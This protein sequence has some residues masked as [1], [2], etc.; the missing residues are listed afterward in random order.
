MTDALGTFVIK[1]ITEYP[2]IVWTYLFG[3]VGATVLR[4]GWPN[5][6]DRPRWVVML[7]ALA[8]IF[9]ANLSGPVKL[10]VKPKS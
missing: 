6:T 4:A 7:L 9:Q 1:T 8:D 10:L 5:E 3:F 2:W